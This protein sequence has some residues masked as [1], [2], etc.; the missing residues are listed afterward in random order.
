MNGRQRRTVIVGWGVLDG[1][2]DAA[3]LRS[4]DSLVLHVLALG[5]EAARCIHTLLE[6]I[7]LPAKD[8]IG[9]LSNLPLASDIS[10]IK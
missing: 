4:I 7:A 6:G 3:L 2:L 9:V 1:L 10:S 5:A 8:V